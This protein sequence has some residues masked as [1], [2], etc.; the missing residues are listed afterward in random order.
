MDTGKLLFVLL[1]IVYAIISDYS[2]LMMG[3]AF[4]LPL[5]NGLPGNYIF[6]L[7]CVIIVV[8]GWKKLQVNPL[9]WFAFTLIIISELLHILLFASAPNV[10]NYIG[11]CAAIFLLLVVGGSDD[12]GSDNSKNALA[13]CIGSVVMLTVILLN[14]SMMMES[15]IQDIGI[16]VGDT[17]LF[18]DEDKMTL[19]TNPNNI[20]LYSI[21]TISISFSLWFYKK[22]PLWSFV[23]LAALAFIAGM[24]SMSRTWMLSLIV[25]GFFFLLFNK[26]K[27]YIPTIIVIVIAVGIYLLFERSGSNAVDMFVER[28]RGSEINTAG[29][30]TILFAAYHNWMFANGWA[31]IFGTGAQT[32]K[33]VTMIYDSELSS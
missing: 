5:A 1:A 10:S 12:E 32:Y 19:G 4:L 25:F 11:Y 6:P 15:Q 22:T 29:S 21:A 30:R 27:S 17:S 14:F 2:H 7:L 18:G 13:F 20:G 9:V 28:F 8:K 3:T 33:E 26:G 23:I 16:R 31:L 24:S